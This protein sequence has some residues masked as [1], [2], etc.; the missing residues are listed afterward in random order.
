VSSD[1]GGAFLLNVIVIGLKG[2]AKFQTDP[3][4]AE[5]RVGKGEAVELLGANKRAVNQAIKALKKA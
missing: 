5:M 3:P 4:T 1:F 2:D